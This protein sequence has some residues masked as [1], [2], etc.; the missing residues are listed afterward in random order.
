MNKIYTLFDRSGRVT[1]T[2]SGSFSHVISPTLL[3]WEGFHYEGEYDD[4]YYFHEGEPT[5][6]PEN[7]TLVDGLSLIDVPPNSTIVIDDEAYECVDGGKV[8][9]VLNQHG[10]YTVTVYSFPHMD[11]E[12]EI[13]YQP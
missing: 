1:Q 11:K 2:V 8:D 4:S 7:T 13:D 5:K 10:K 6:R 9:L 12:F 3:L